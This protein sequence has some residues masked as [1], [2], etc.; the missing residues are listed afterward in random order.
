LKQR[1]GI[2]DIDFR[3]FPTD[4]RSQKADNQGASDDQ[5]RIPAAAGEPN[6]PHVANTAAML[7]FPISII[8]ALPTLRMICQIVRH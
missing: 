7:A 8:S 3:A 4:E 5:M 6:R 1:R 2:G